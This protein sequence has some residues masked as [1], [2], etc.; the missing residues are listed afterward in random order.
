M[1]ICGYDVPKGTVVMANFWALSMNQDYWENPEEFNPYRFLEDDGMSLKPRPQCHI[2]F[3][4]GK[5][6]AKIQ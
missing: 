3:S 2:P 4:I 1:K 5:I 6:I